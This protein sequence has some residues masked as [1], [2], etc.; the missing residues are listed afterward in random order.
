MSELRTHSL[1]HNTAT[2]Q[3]NIQMHSDGST[4]IRDL[5]NLAPNLI[6]N[7]AM[8]VAK[9]TT[10]VDFN[11]NAAYPAVDRWKTSIDLPGGVTDLK[12][13]QDTD[14]PPGFNHSYKVSPNQAASGALAV[15]DR[16]WLEQVI[17]GKN[18]GTLA[19]G[20]AN[21]KG[22][23]LSFWIKSNLT[24][25]VGIELIIP[26]A[27]SLHQSVSISKAD[28]WEFKSVPIAANTADLPVK[29]NAAGL[30]IGFQF[31]AGPTF[32][33]GSRTENKWANTAADVRA[34]A[35]NM[36]LYSSAN[37]Y[38]NLTGVQLTA[39]DAAFEYQHE[40]YG[41]T[42]AKCER[43]F[44]TPAATSTNVRFG[45]GLAADTDRGEVTVQ[46]HTEM[47]TVPALRFLGNTTAGSFS[48]SDT[49]TGHALDSIAIYEI[50]S[51]SSVVCLIC[52]K[53]AAAPNM[54]V[55]R[56]YYLENASQSTACLGFDAE[57]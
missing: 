35:G 40:D 22:A 10:S 47:R 29:T 41:T 3:A 11:T 57:L 52:N 33:G 54:T 18:L 15:A 56:F 21:A 6:I 25:K 14:A 30:S 51:S 39:T 4:T 23:T 2:G 42:L 38:V 43:Y 27:R 55:K 53:T 50:T 24:D 34:P 1:R 45:Q 12:F 20:T 49:T 13:E 19:Y 17:E 26:G 36:N 48:L 32:T 31:A 5:K 7:G 9:R 46:L 8:A 44:Y 37:N 16:I 28:T